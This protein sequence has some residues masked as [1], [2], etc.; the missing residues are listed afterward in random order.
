MIQFFYVKISS[1]YHDKLIRDHLS[2]SPKYFQNKILK[3]KRWQD[4]QLSL[5][6]RLLLRY[7]LLEKDI[8]LNEERIIFNTEG[9]PFIV[10]NDIKFN[11]THSG[12]IVVCAIG[13]SFE[14]GIDIEILT[15]R[16]IEEFK[17]QML[18]N[19]WNR[20]YLSNNPLVSF[21]TYWTQKE[22]VI[23]AIGKGLSIP[24]KSFE[25]INNQTRVYGKA[26]H[27]KEI[28]IDDDYVCF[29]AS[30]KNVSIETCEIKEVKIQSLLT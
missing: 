5:L 6:G 3:Y 23:K 29:L 1:E 16:N 26:Y 21:Y 12:E 24:L 8:D 13:Q 20:I 15:A 14:I 7:A 18:E 2:S 22:S 30:N 9:K 25:I 19:E 11:I 4:A 28:P 27:L 10:E 17:D